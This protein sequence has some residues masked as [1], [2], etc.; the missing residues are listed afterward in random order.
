MR[1]LA[2]FSLLLVIVQG[3]LGGLT[4]LYRLPIAVSVSHGV[5]AQTFMVMLIV[6]A[7][8]ESSEWKK[9]VAIR[10][11]GAAGK[12]GV[13]KH[14]VIFSC[15]VYVQ[16]IVAALMRHTDSGLAVLDFPTMGGSWLP[17][18]DGAM[19]QGVNKLRAEV[20]LYPVDMFQV[21]IHILHRTLAALLGL[22]AFYIGLWCA[23]PKRIRS[24]KIV[25]AARLLMVLVV[26]QFLLGVAS[27]WSL[28]APTLTSIHVM[29]GAM[30]LAVS[31]LL[32]L[33]AF[34]LD[35]RN[36]VR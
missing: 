16:L 31:C 36:I 23:S 7:Y 15:L 14:A 26:L 11:E 9:R 33:R 10:T 22:Y 1:Y 30:L 35:G 12:V 25:F 3:M 6:L 28:T 34:P 18:F 24:A 19:L 17:L 20:S 4:V 29:V 5:I 27:V 13:F 21:S 2:L 32:A 8:A